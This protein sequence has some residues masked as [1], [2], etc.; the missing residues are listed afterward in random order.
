MPPLV[1]FALLAMFKKSIIYR[2]KTFEET[3]KIT[4]LVTKKHLIHMTI[5]L[6]RRKKLGGNKCK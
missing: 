1:G 6:G 2:K 4:V 3:G 5:A